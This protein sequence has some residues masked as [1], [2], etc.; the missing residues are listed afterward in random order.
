[1][2]GQQQLF[3]HHGRGQEFLGPGPQGLQDR[4]AVAA[5]ADGEDRHVGKFDRQL[6]DELQRLVVVGVESDDDQVGLVWRATS[7]KNS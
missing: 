5:R 6:L 3:E 7:M 1:M 2:Q 4:L